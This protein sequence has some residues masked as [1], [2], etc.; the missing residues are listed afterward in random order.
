MSKAVRTLIFFVLFLLFAS[1]CYKV[2]MFSIENSDNKEIPLLNNQLYEEDL[3][4]VRL[5]SEDIITL[6]MTKGYEFKIGSDTL[7]NTG[8]RMELKYL[9]KNNVYEV[10][11][12][13]NG[14]MELNK[15]TKEVSE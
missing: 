11:V 14:E 8:T 12:K 9:L 1:L 5:S 2:I 3:N 7:R 15:V 4:G 10:E 6:I 13:N